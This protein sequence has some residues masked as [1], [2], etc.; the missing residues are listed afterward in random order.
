M[1]ASIPF[2]RGAP[3]RVCVIGAGAMGISLAAVLGQST[4]VVIVARDPVR[5]EHIE[6]NGARVQ[7]LAN[8]TA[9]PLVVRDV[10]ALSGAGPIDAIF[11]ATKTTSIDDVCTDLSPLLGSIHETEHRPW[12]ISF[13]NGIESGRAL[14]DRLGYPKVIRMVLHYGARM[15]HEG[16]VEV[17]QSKPPHSIGSPN[18]GSHEACR[19]LARTLTTG[20]METEFVRDIEPVVWTKGITNASMNPVAALVNTSVGEVLDSPAVSIVA[21]LIREGIQVALAEGIDLGPKI[22]ERVWHALECARPHTPSMVEDIRSGRS[23]EVGQLNRQIVQHA[24]SSG[25]QVPTHELI[26]ALIETFDWRVFKRARRNEPHV[27]GG[28]HR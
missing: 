4:E 6:R 18:P 22:E 15:T 23:S 7:G 16:G 21:K 14:S 5:A 24:Q 10:R 25:T 2:P 12:I 19:V 26:T 27:H 11:V 9:F 1:N 8:Q 13:Q 20:G 28:T 17:V 3:E